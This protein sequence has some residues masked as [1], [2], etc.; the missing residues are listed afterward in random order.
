VQKHK[1]PEGKKPYK[2]LNEASDEHKSRLEIYANS[3]KNNIHD[4]DNKVGYMYI[5]KLI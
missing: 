2:R 1:T 4:K 3:M 5:A